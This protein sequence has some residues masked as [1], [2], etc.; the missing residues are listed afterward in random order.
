MPTPSPHFILSFRTSRARNGCP[1]RTEAFVVVGYDGGFDTD[2]RI[3]RRS[4]GY[5]SRPEYA[6]IFGW[7]SLY[8]EMQRQG[9]N[10]AEAHFT[11]VPSKNEAPRTV[12][13]KEVL[14]CAKAAPTIALRIKPA[15]E[16]AH[17]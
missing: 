5:F 12:P 2:D 10:P 3:E 7:G 17:A 8:Q 16:P 4:L 11:E 13:L 15:A 9:L 14:F 1:R 6:R